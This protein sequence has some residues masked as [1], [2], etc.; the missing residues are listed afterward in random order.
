MKRFLIP[1]NLQYFADGEGTESANTSEVAEQT[2]ETVETA[3]TETETDSVTEEVAEP[4]TQ[5]AETNRAFADMRRRME[6]AERKAAEV[7]ALYAKQ[8]G[9]Y[10][11][12][13]TGQP[14]RSAADYAEAMAAQE[15]IK[16]REELKANNINPDLIDNLI[17]QSPVVRQA[18]AATREL[19]QYRMQQQI[20]EDLNKILALDKRFNSIEQLMSDPIMGEVAGYIEQH[21]GIRADEA[22]KIVNYD[23]ALTSNTAAA[24]QAAINSIKGKNHLATGTALNVDDSAEDIPAQQL[25]MYKEAFPGKTVKELKALYNRAL[26][27]RK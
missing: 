5:S 9:G 8:F 26:S 13:E 20:S 3:D 22:Y 2:T 14:I 10:S 12:P 27:A 1:M 25:E 17:A 4:Q 16:A 21:P 7:D 11:N 19:N 6:A 23:R 15:R 18:E 24:K